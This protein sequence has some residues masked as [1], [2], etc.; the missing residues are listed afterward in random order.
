MTEAEAGVT[1][2]Q[3][4]LKPE[5][6]EGS[7]QTPQG[8]PPCNTLDLRLLALVPLVAGCQICPW[9][10]PQGDSCPPGKPACLSLLLE[11]SSN[12]TLQV[13]GPPNLLLFSLWKSPHFADLPLDV[14]T[15]IPQHPRSEERGCHASH[16]M[17][18]VVTQD[19]TPSHR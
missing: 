2:P 18:C 4:S 14:H 1:R 5:K 10:P 16:R 12:S 7:S 8:A 15:H 3:G 9:S 6:Q 11:P 19:G 17:G 13:Q